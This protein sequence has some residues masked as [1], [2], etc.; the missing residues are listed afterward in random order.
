MASGPA[1]A[2]AT[3]PNDWQ[4]VPATDWQDVNTAASSSAPS[5]T[6]LTGIVPH[7]SDTLPHALEDVFSNIG[8][9][10]LGALETLGRISPWGALADK[11]M[12]KPTIYGEAY[13]A[14]T[15]P[16]QTVK[17]L[18]SAF[19]DLAQHPLENIEGGIGAAGAG[20]M[21]PEG[22]NL[23]EKIPT[24]AKAGKLFAEAMEK[25]AN[26]PVPLSPQTLDPLQRTQQLAMTGGKPFGTADKLFQRIQ[27]I[28]PL[29]YQEARDFSQNMSLS[30]EEK[31]GLK[32]SMRYEVPRL[33]RAFNNDVQTAADN[34]GVGD[35]HRQ[36]MQTYRR[37]SQIADVGDKVKKYGGR[38]A[39]GAAGLG[40]AYKAYHILGGN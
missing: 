2:V 16:G 11:V 1:K 20:A 27:T 12:G 40:G 22:A 30:P 4:E 25:A 8:G 35:V 14:I 18:K 9:G 13:D 39:L 21:L 3:E 28:N 31:M 10:G 5:A 38:A 32:R 24:K 23:L 7:Q 17:G 19:V 15:H 37:A 34:A 36:A 26:E 6:P 29:S 33:S